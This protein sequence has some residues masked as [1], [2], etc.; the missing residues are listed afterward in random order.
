VGFFC[1]CWFLFANLSITLAPIPDADLVTSSY[2][3]LLLESGKT[4]HS[5][6]LKFGVLESRRSLLQHWTHRG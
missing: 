2:F 3:L 4:I 1:C 5:L 6:K